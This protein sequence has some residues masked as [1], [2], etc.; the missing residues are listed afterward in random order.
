MTFVPSYDTTSYDICFTVDT[1]ATTASF[2]AAALAEK[3]FDK[4]GEGAFAKATLIDN[5]K[6][7]AEDIGYLNQDADYGWQ[8]K[9]A[10]GF[11]T[12]SS[13]KSVATTVFG[14]QTKP[15]VEAK[16]LQKVSANELDISTRT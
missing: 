5:I 13:C 16:K 9:A 12:V 15:K 8:A 2:A 14:E 11:S 6:E 4:Y 7:C 10:E 3:I 1:E